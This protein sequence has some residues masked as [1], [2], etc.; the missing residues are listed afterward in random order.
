MLFYTHSDAK[1]RCSPY[2]SKVG[3]S[4]LKLLIS[5]LMEIRYNGVGST[6]KQR[7]KQHSRALSGKEYGMEATL[8]LAEKLNDERKRRNL[9]LEQVAE[10]TGVSRAALG[11]YENTDE[12]PKD[13]SPYNLEKLAR[14]Y[15]VSIDYLMGLT[16][17]RDHPYTPIE[18]LHLSDD[19]IRTLQE[20][21]FNHRLLSELITSEYFIGLM[22]DLE[23][24]VDGHVSA[25][26]RA[27]NAALQQ[28][29]D[30]IEQRFHPDENDLHFRT[31]EIGQIDQHK[32]MAEVITDDLLRIAHDLREQH[33]ND[34]NASPD[35]DVAEQ[36][37]E[38]AKEAIAAGGSALEQAQ[39]LMCMQLGIDY[40]KIDTLDRMALMR[41]LK[42]SPSF[43][44]A[45][46]Q[47]GKKS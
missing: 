42:K 14:F 37:A 35:T 33:K 21:R 46:N 43:K 17:Q 12:A 41:I 36:I 8:T 45:I 18:S 20:G 2:V 13:V 34:V 4:V 16:E 1:R 22:I 11:K 15:G 19:A 23:I 6:L 29:R 44:S 47:R 32:Y 3:N 25:R 9:T 31:L 30:E 10:Q 40:D 27:L 5:T 39:R 24:Y 38:N 26:I 7:K 28:T